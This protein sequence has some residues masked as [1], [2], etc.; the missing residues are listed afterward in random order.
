[1]HR[2]NN[3]TQRIYCK[4]EAASFVRR[5][6]EL[7]VEATDQGLKVLVDDSMRFVTEGFNVCKER[8]W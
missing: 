7:L 6:A 4:D 2:T 8:V 3:H 5:C 1:M